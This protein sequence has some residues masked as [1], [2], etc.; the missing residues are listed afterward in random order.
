MGKYRCWLAYV[1]VGDTMITIERAH[2]GY[3]PVATFP[4]NMKD[5]HLFLKLQRKAR[6]GNR[7]SW[8]RRPSDFGS[9]VHHGVIWTGDPRE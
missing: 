7:G 5:Q 6:E 1:Y 9:D 4:P 8:G 3:M 2:Q